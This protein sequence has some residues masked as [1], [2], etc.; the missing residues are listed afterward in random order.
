MVDKKQI[1]VS[2]EELFKK[3]KIVVQHLESKKSEIKLVPAIMVI[4]LFL[5][6]VANTCM[7]LILTSYKK[8]IVDYVKFEHIVSEAIQ[9]SA[10]IANKIEAVEGRTY[11]FSDHLIFNTNELSLLKKDYEK[12]FG[13]IGDDQYAKPDAT[14]KEE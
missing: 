8:H 11:T 9:Q 5:N 4:L 14:P 10:I 2:D 1:V 6:L 7:I 12:R 13:L 3:I